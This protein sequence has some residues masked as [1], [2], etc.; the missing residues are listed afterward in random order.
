[1][2]L[3]LDRQSYEGGYGQSPFCEANGDRSLY[4]LKLLP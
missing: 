3:I 1:M 2:I 4:P